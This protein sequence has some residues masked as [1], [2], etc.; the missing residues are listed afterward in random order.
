MKASTDPVSVGHRVGFGQLSTY[1]K[2]TASGA[3][4][5]WQTST[6]YVA[7]TY[8]K[9]GAN[10]YL[11][12]VG[13]TSAS[14]GGPTGTGTGITDGTV[15][16]NY[17]A[18]PTLN[19]MNTKSMHWS[20]QQ[21]Q[22]DLEVVYDNIVGAA[23]QV[24]GDNTIAVTASIEY[25]SG[26][27][28]PLFKNGSR[29][30]T[31]QPGQVDKF[32]PCPIAIP[33]NTQYWI[34][35][36]VYVASGT[37]P[38]HWATNAN[39]PTGCTMGTG[40]N[41]DMTISGNIPVYSQNSAGYQPCNILGRVQTPTPS[42]LLYGDSHLVGYTDGTWPTHSEQGVVC[43]AIGNTYGWS[44]LGVT[45]MTLYQYIFGSLGGP[46]SGAI[47]KGFSHF[48][49]Y[50]GTNDVTASQS[51][52]NIQSN[53]LTLWKWANARGMKVIACTLP[54]VSTST[55]G[56]TTLA[57][58]TVNGGNS[59][60]QQVNSWLRTLPSP[61][62]GLWDIAALLEDGGSASPTGKWVC[63]GAVAQTSD[64][65]HANSAG[66]TLGIPAITLG[67]IGL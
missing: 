2:N 61:L 24:A 28:T 32:D 30:L 33:A 46:Y 19:W 41:V 12:T 9:N 18:S 6:V 31:L 49:D 62:V 36:N 51:F 67:T 50:M 40:T 16:W 53:K 11:C 58:Q 48:V 20:G 25:P 37:W 43:R 56:W 42:L 3:A 54:P 13:G 15:T 65:I 60:R 7:N 47:W 14:S 59:V 26:T 1:T 55:D 4:P 17:I 35:T 63:P 44:N 8:V 34:R 38:L 10:I 22:T 64:G 45:G 5:L 29:T 27:Y 21:Y 66:S 52:A 57:N 39:L 23:Q